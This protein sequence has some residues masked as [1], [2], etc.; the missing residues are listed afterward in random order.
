[1]NTSHS[2]LDAL[3]APTSVAVIG[4]SESNKFARVGLHNLIEW[5]FPRE[6][7]HLVNRTRQEIRGIPC[8]PS[9]DDIEGQ[10]DLA[11][12]LVGR[13]KVPDALRA[14]ARRGA[15]AAVV[16]AAGFELG[17]EVGDRLTEELAQVAEDEGMLLCGPN[18][19]GLADFTS[20]FCAYAG[21]GRLPSRAGNVAV[22]SQSGGTMGQIL[23]AL[24]SRGVGFS[25]L[26]AVGNGTVVSVEDYLQYFAED[27]NTRVIVLYLEGFKDGRSARAAL[28]TARETGKPIVALWPSRDE[29]SIAA[30]RSHTA[31]IVRNADLWTAHLEQMGVILVD[32]L[33]TLVETV[34]LFSS[35]VHPA[36]DTRLAYVSVSGGD[37]TLAAHIA[38]KR[39]L[40]L[41]QLSEALVD[42]MRET[43]ARPE[44][45]ANPFD[46]QGA[47]DFGNLA[48]AVIQIWEWWDAL[49][50]EDIDIVAIRPHFRGSP[51]PE[52]IDQLRELQR[53]ANEAGKTFVLVSPF[54]YFV[55]PDVVA[56]GGEN[57]NGWHD[58]WIPR[59][60]E[61]RIPFLI[62]WDRACEAFRLFAGYWQQ[63]EIDALAPRDVQP[64]DA[65]VQTLIAS[66]A[67]RVGRG[68]A[69]FDESDAILQ[70]VGV[71]TSRTIR[72]NSVD[73]ALKAA[74]VLGYPVV[75]KADSR[76][77]PHRA[78]I[79]AVILDVQDAAHLR[80]AYGVIIDRCVAHHG[81]DSE[82]GVL[83]QHRVDPGQEFIVGLTHD[84]ELGPVVAI[85]P[86]GTSVES[87]TGRLAVA[88]T[89]ISEDYLRRMIC[90]ISGD[91]RKDV[92]SEHPWQELAGLVR[93]FSSLSVELARFELDI[94]LNPVIVGRSGLSIVDVLITRD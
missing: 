59:L 51:H 65:K 8:V 23:E 76:H 18:T 46:V 7:L 34:V 84:A 57:M 12:V 68:V 71:S 29:A 83:V 53:R 26:A 36:S 81:H 69:L 45:V 88:A 27:E 47:I 44:I 49:L 30:A 31:T 17:D 10:V 56:A 91:S 16:V 28:R 40:R 37:S 38:S 89:P 54:R 61:E 25:K 93:A 85:G 70:S 21:T 94:E 19:T 35:D 11:F 52:Q 62:D 74:E 75:L 66:T 22:L 33:A 39:G 50:R 77:V 72:A 48:A 6:N 14:A 90:T 82:D 20:R 5:R 67:D 64:L 92:I 79:G 13:E 73:D 2:S 41:P 86:G 43:F 15:R 78:R 1:M 32:D 58:E 55:A 3:F 63:L 42:Q 9:V 4:A 80:R 24:D 87:H 60:A